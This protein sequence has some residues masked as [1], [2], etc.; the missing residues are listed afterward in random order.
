MFRMYEPMQDVRKEVANLTRCCDMLLNG[1]SINTPLTAREEELL[2]AYIER[3]QE[4]L[5][6]FDCRQVTPGPTPSSHEHSYD[7]SSG[8]LSFSSFQYSNL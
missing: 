7:A 1:D 4:K 5:H 3:L 2:R 6:L 8:P